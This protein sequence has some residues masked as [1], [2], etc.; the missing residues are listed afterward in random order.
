MKKPRIGIVTFHRAVNY[1]AVLQAYALQKSMEKLGVNCD[2][3]D[4]RNKK[5]EEKH[6][7][8]S[9]LRCRTPKDFARFFLRPKKRNPKYKKF[10]AFRNNHLSLSAPCSTAEELSKLADAYDSFLVGSDQVWNYNITGFDGAYFLDFVEDQ[11]KR[12][13]YAASFGIDTIP[14]EYQKQYKNYLDE[15]NCI[16]VREREGQKLVKDLTSR[17][18]EIV[19]D[20]VLLL[21]KKEWSQISANP[22]EM[23]S[24]DYILSHHYS[25][26]PTMNTFLEEL[27]K[28]TGCKI[29]SVFR[30]SRDPMNAITADNPG[31]LEFIELYKN[32]K[33][34]VTNSYHGAI[35]AIIFQKNFFLEM[36][37]PPA[38]VNSR[39]RMLLDL[40]DLGSREIIDGKNGS[41][42]E[43]IQYEKVVEILSQERVRSINYLKKIVQ[44]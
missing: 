18:V 11:K 41:I 4:Y 44:I 16:A 9:F 43:S 38:K 1:G 33:Y 17:D 8:S 28:K 7:E 20:P 31:P 40:F 35:F 37:P 26:T 15:F 22:V 13:A 2:I 39:L 23:P 36:L 32:A 29:L 27:S 5:L 21:N 14:P 24:S 12:N 25:N 3:I 30:G 19:L 6:H 42:K 10:Q 34:V